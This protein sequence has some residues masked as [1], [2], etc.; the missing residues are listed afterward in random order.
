V[1][2]I[3]AK[4]SV[5]DYFGRILT[6][7]NKM[8]IHSERMTDVVII[9]KILRSMTLKYN[10]VVC[11]IKKSIDLDTLSLDEPQSSLLVHEKWIN[12]HIVDEQ[13]LQI[14]YEPQ[15][16]GMSDDR[17]SYRGRG[18]FRLDKTILKCYNLHELGHFQCECP[19]KSRYTRVNF[20]ETSEEMLLIAYMDGNEAGRD[21]LLFLDSGSSNHMYG[22]RELF[23]QFDNNFREKVKLSNN[24]SLIIQ[25]KGNI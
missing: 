25:G 19:K 17:G 9:E 13:A 8:R 11:S 23:S 12:H 24:T 4:E 3:K 1:L 7:T 16:R 6:T 21:H 14:I 15:L 22:K 5:N 18:K 2:H 20:V 10:Y